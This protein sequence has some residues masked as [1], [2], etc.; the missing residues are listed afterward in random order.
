MLQSEH[1]L[2]IEKGTL[3]YKILGK[4]KPILLLAG[5]PGFDADYL[6]PVA[7]HLAENQQ[8]ILLHQRG[9]GKSILETYDLTTVKFDKCVEDIE[10]LRLHLQIPKWSILA[11]SWGGLVGT[12]YAVD[13][14]QYLEKLILINSAGLSYHIF[15]YLFDNVLNHLSGSDYR[16]AVS[17]F[18]SLPTSTNPIQDSIE[19]FKSIQSAYFFNKQAAVSFSASIDEH[20]ISLAFYNLMVHDL[21]TNAIDFKNVCKSLLKP[22]VLIS[23]R[24]DVVDGHSVYETMHYLPNSQLHIIEQCGHYPW[25]DQK[26]QFLKLLNMIE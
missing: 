17:L 11:H 25:L 23:G 14:Q 10:I 22:V 19:L 20:F 2:P 9:T 15:T 8:V 7:T 4:G 26:E 6:M 5:G 18:Q 13:F 24:Q 21:M 3:H 16:K 1:F 12:K